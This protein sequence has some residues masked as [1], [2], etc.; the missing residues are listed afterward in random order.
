MIECVQGCC[1]CCA[2][3]TVELL[4]LILLA[5]HWFSQ[6][7]LDSVIDCCLKQQLPRFLG[8]LWGLFLLCCVTQSVFS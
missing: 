4:G 8:V 7:C 5:P 3:I 6:L 2:G 1:F